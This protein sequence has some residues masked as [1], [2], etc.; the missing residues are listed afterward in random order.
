VRVFAIKWFTKF[1]RGENI[2][3]QALCNAAAEVAAGVFDADLGGSLYKKRVAR[4]GQGKSAGYR[5]IVGYKDP[6]T[7][8]VVFLYGFPKSVADN[9]TD[10]A[11]DVF[12]AAA[13]AFIR[14]TDAQVDKLVAEKKYRELECGGLQP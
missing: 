6:H 13:E 8:R 4:E 11:R 7:D 14:A 1:A 12:S 2:G 3:D 10:A 5:L 9:I